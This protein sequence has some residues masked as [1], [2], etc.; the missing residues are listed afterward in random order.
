MVGS[1]GGCHW[2][3]KP[4]RLQSVSGSQ[5]PDLDSRHVAMTRDESEKGETTRDSGWTC[6]D[7]PSTTEST[8]DEDRWRRMP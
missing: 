2:A 8:R 6:W 4:D 5:S 7:V 1:G 3:A